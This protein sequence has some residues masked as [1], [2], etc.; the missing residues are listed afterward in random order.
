MVH[1]SLAIRIIAQREGSPFSTVVEILLVELLELSFKIL[2][3]G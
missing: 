2:R 1:T 3:E